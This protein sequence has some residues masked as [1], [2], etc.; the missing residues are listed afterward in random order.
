[1][2]SAI[3]KQPNSLVIHISVKSRAP[4]SYI[5][6]VDF[7]RSFIC[8]A[9]VHLFPQPVNIATFFAE[10][11]ACRAEVYPGVGIRIVHGV[12]N[13]LDWVFSL[14]AKIFSANYTALHLGVKLVNL[15][16][17]MYTA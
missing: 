10:H 17:A 15:L 12:L 14:S 1:M 4:Q 8:G 5:W 11:S 16:A 9:T 2:L 7:L 3:G 13:F 6:R